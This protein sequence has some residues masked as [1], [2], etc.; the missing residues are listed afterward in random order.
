MKMNS[1]FFNENVKKQFDLY[2]KLT[3]DLVKS[4]EGL[5]ENDYNIKALK[6]N[7]SKIES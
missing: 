7:L 3:K 2:S 4:E 1:P 5:V 6:E